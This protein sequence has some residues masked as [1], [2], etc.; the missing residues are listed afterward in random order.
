MLAIGGE[1][2]LWDPLLLDW[3]VWMRRNASDV[4]LRSQV[5]V[6]DGLL[7]QVT[8]G[9]LDLAVVYAPRHWPGLK[10]EMIME[11]ELVLVTTDPATS[12][13]SDPDYVYVD[14]GEDFAAHHGMS[15]PH[16][17]DPG[18][19]VGLGPLGL[20]Y[21]IEVG[22]AGYFRKRAVRPHLASGRLHVVPHAPQFTHPVYAVYTEGAESEILET[23]LRGLCE[24]AEA[25]GSPASDNPVPESL[26]TMMPPSILGSAVASG[27]ALR[28]MKRI[29]MLSE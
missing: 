12:D 13:V 26:E 17:S 4:A 6:S 23:A 21:I 28:E 14:W 5:G 10:V 8:D 11:E 25:E 7:R 27:E 19:F 18:L 2:S 20:D 1:L 3:M 22:G 16:F 15:F 24:V 29:A 9:V